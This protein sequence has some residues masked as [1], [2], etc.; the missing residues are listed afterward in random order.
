MLKIIVMQLTK[1]KLFLNK[2]YYKKIVI[3]QNMLN[4]LN[5]FYIIKY[6]FYNIE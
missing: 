6:V 2:I 5:I 1:S 3:N 4:V